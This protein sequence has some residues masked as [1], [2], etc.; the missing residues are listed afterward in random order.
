MEGRGMASLRAVLVHET[1]HRDSQLQEMDSLTTL[2]TTLRAKQLRLYGL[3]G[4]MYLDQLEGATQLF[5]AEAVLARSFRNHA[6]AKSDEDTI[7][8]WCTEGIMDTDR[9]ESL[10]QRIGEIISDADVRDRAEEE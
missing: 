10:C 9:F 4:Q 3:I 2:A 8:E 7:R 5:H 6:F 1:C